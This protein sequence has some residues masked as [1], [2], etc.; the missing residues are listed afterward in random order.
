MSIDEKDKGQSVNTSCKDLAVSSLA[1]SLQNEPINPFVDPP[2]DS[3]IDPTSSNFSYKSWLQNFTSFTSSEPTRYPRLTSGLS[4]SNLSVYGQRSPTDYQ[5]DVLNILLSFSSLFRRIAGT[6]AQSIEILHSFDGLV[7]S[8][9]LLLVL[10]R[11]GSGC[12]TLLKTISCDTHGLIVSK[13]SSRNYKGIGAKDM[14]E[15]FRGEAIYMAEN[16]VHFPQLTVGDTLLFAAGARAPRDGTFPDVSRE[17]YAR[18]MRDVVMAALGIGHT[19][20]TA[21]GNH[22]IKGVSGGE[23]KRVSIAEAMLSGSPL[24]CWDNSTRGL[25]SAN[26]LE[27]CNILKLQAE[28]TGITACVS[29]YQAS[30]GIYDVSLLDNLFYILSFLLQFAGSHPIEIGYNADSPDLR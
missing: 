25:D 19:V 12:S 4:F 30:Q 8:G 10:G 18:H 15:K 29:L 1:G 20:D 28:M 16:D 21:V 27:F 5:K 11:P 17:M 24:Q 6:H 7:N 13:D 14:H 3:P 2:K 23:K 26:A 9:E 22:V